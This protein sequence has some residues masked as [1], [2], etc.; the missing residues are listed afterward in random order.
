MEM[1]V[2]HGPSPSRTW[3]ITLISDAVCNSWLLLYVRNV[4][5]PVGW[6]WWEDDEAQFLA[7]QRSADSQ[8]RA[9]PSPSPSPSRGLLYDMTEL[10]YS[11]ITSHRWN[12]LLAQHRLT[13]EPASQ[14]E[15]ENVP[16]RPGLPASSAA[17]VRTWPWMMRPRPHERT[18]TPASKMSKVAKLDGLY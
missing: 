6:P 4:F 14:P 5:V 7:V 17:R 1:A 9:P 12:H 8:P 15:N 2:F 3:T 18:S 16:N 10:F 13:P 11:P